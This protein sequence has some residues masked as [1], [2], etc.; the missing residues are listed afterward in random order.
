MIKNKLNYKKIKCFGENV[1]KF[2]EYFKVKKPLVVRPDKRLK[3]VTAEVVSVVSRKTGKKGFIIRYNP[4]HISKLDYWKIIYVVL[5]EL[6]H[7]K[8]KQSYNKFDR[9][10]R[11]EKFA[12]GII[13]KHFK[14]QYPRYRNYI[15]WYINSRKMDIYKKVFLKLIKN[16]RI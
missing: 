5:H 6:G 8:T 12:Q 10:Y 7:I 14:L 4:V 2:C 13:K 15:F 16:G 11:A 9:E 3:I 1:Y